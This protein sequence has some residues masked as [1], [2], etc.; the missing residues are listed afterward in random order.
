M[1]ND[2]IEYDWERS[3]VYIICNNI[4]GSR[5]GRFVCYA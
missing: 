5:I 3:G 4:P 2:F 1:K